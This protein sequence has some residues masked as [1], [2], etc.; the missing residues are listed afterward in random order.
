MLVNAKRSSVSTNDMDRV[1]CL[2]HILKGLR[3]EATY[4]EAQE[5]GTSLVEFFEAFAMEAEDGHI[6]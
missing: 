4:D 1:E 2:R 3:I 5:I 6:A